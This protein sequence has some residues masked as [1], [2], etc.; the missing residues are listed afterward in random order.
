[1]GY[2]ISILTPS[3]GYSHDLTLTVT[4]HEIKYQTST[5]SKKYFV[6]IK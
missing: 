1:M 5:F 2:N 4:L 3:Y 6:L